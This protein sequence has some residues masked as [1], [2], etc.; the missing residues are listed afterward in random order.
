MVGLELN[1]K[2]KKGHLDCWPANFK[3]K[4]LSCLVIKSTK[5]LTARCAVGQ[6]TDNT[7]Y[8][9]GVLSVLRK[10]NRQILNGFEY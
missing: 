7:E 5:E 6:M 3:M 4:L 2:Y 1:S 9:T 8:W 10:R